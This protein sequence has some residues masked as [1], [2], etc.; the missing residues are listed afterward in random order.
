MLK[1]EY[2]KPLAV[3]FILTM[4][5][6][7]PS[8]MIYLVSTGAMI[9]TAIQLLPNPRKAKRRMSA[10]SEA[11]LQPMTPSILPGYPDPIINGCLYF[12]TLPSIP[13]LQAVFKEAFL[14]YT[15]FNSVPIPGKSGLWEWAD[16]GMNL[17]DHFWK[18]EVASSAEADKTVEDMMLKSLRLGKE[19]PLWEICL[20]ENT[21][22]GDSL[23]LLRIH[24]SL[25]DGISLM[26]AFL[27]M[28]T[29]K[30]GS[31]YTMPDFKGKARKRPSMLEM[32]IDLMKSVKE[33]VSLPKGPYDSILAF[34]EPKKKELKFS[35]T[36]TVVKCP[37]VELAWIKKMGKNANVTINDVLMC[38]TAGA[39]RRYCAYMGDDGP[40][41]SSVLCRALLPL[42]FPRPQISDDLEPFK[43][44]RNNWCFVSMKLLVGE[45]DPIKR[46]AKTSV[47][48][49]KLKTTMVAPVQLGLQNGLVPLLPIAAA[50]QTLHDLFS[51]HSVV[52]SNVPG[53]QEL[54]CV[55]GQEVTGMQMVFPNLLTQVGILSYNGKI[56]MNFTLDPKLILESEKLP[57]FYLEELEEMGK[58]LNCDRAQFQG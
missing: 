10:S 17:N 13:E 55:A 40:K 53:P 7:L 18:V 57:Q 14:K 22:K 2:Y 23:I 26:K 1:P 54:V 21:G 32:A 33:V 28:I 43:G 56:F 37:E 39:I 11:M 58:V 47:I 49:T 51:R 3:G 52:F 27:G 46:L 20:I 4:P 8:W 29:L 9:Y 36:R 30:D 42:A 19:A 34:N 44:L 31:P 16:R 45:S 48:S 5:W 41:S 6:L 12:Q 38:A 25:G 50:H 35:G 15:R 24:H